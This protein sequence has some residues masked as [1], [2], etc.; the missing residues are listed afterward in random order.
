M[1]D[2]GGAFPKP[3][4]PNE[5]SQSRATQSIPPAAAPQA[6]PVLLSEQDPSCWDTRDLLLPKYPKD[7]A[8]TPH[9][10]PC[11]RAWGAAGLTLKGS[12]EGS[13][14]LLLARGAGSTDGAGAGAA[15]SFSSAAWPGAAGFV[16]SDIAVLGSSLRQGGHQA[17]VP[18]AG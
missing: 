3:V 4:L 13:S 14:P 5:P 17:E 8:T 12:V 10:Q 18:A 1:L 15:F 11:R 7:A 9:P 6:A 2:L 16:V